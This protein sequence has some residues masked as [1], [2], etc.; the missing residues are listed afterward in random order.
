MALWPHPIY[1][2]FSQPNH[3]QIGKFNRTNST[4]LE[5]LWPHS[6]PLSMTEKFIH[7]LIYQY[8]QCNCG[9]FA[10]SESHNEKKWTRTRAVFR[11][12]F[13]CMHGLHSSLALLPF[14][15]NA[16]S[17]GR[18]GLSTRPPP[19]I[20]ILPETIFYPF[21]TQLWFPSSGADKR[22]AQKKKKKKRSILLLSRKNWTAPSATATCGNNV[23]LLAVRDEGP[24]LSE[25][26][27]I[28]PLYL[29]PVAQVKLATYLFYRDFCHYWLCSA[30]ITN[31]P[32]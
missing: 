2:Q 1:Q 17:A 9:F 25:T 22:T 21:D 4:V 23:C 13:A 5:N 31:A 10:E 12:R 18:L 26:I 7:N 28:K 6:V 32:R 8:I 24:H 20:Y 14:A 29:W 30:H 16:G 27:H 19:V 11:E 3:M 15:C